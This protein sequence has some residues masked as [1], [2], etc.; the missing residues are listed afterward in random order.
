MSARYDTLGRE[1]ATRRV[2]DIRIAR[3]IDVALSG[4]TRIVNIGA[5]A[6]SYEPCDKALVAVEPSA[7]MIAQRSA[8]AAPVVQAVAEALPFATNQFD[9]AMAVLTMHHWTDWRRGLEEALRVANGRLVLLT[10][11]NEQLP[12]WLYDYFPAMESV[13]RDLFPGV[14]ELRAVLGDF[15]VETV[16]V[17]HDCTDGFLCAYW[18]R[19]EAYLD[20]GVR[21]SI[22]L[23]AMIEEVEVGVDRLAH[24]LASGK[25]HADNTGLL[26]VDAVDFGYRLLSTV[27][28]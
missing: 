23:F 6:G 25:W 9:L 27:S 12:F 1:Y 17:P 4:A 5:G 11:L 10:W 19:P 20:V 16:P 14:D 8:S 15:S 18:R 2:P 26:D 22:S 13:N 3:Q 21:Q 24:D 7:T 28:D